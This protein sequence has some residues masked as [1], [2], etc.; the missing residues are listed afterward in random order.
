M[1]QGLLP[2]GIKSGGAV[3]ALPGGL[4]GPVEG[5]TRRDVYGAY[6]E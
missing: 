6:R 2:R 4:F 3:T 1:D 5:F